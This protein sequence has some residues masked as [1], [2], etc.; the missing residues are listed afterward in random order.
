VRKGSSESAGDPDII[1]GGGSLVGLSRVT[2]TVVTMTEDEANALGQPVE[3]RKQFFR[4]DGAKG[5]YA[6]PRA[7]AWHERVEHEL[8]NGELVAAAH[9]WTPPAGDVTLD[10]CLQLLQAVARGHDGEPLSPKLTD[11]AR[12]L[13]QACIRIG[14]NNETAQQA[15]LRRLKDE[16]GVTV[17]KFARTGR[18]KNQ[19]WLGLRTRERK[20]ERV[21]WSDA[22]ADEEAA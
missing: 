5:N 19:T 3:H 1:R 21:L 18:S 11:H 10:D 9:P 16:H 4:V 6:P 7:A 8:A 2:L 17:H 14:I 13:K 22:D 20:P 12:S 15:A